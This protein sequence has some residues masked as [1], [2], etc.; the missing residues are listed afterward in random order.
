MSRAPV[1]SC[2]NDP[3]QAKCPKVRVV[4][5][6]NG[7]VWAPEGA[8]SA[9]RARAAFY[10]WQCQLRVSDGSPYKASGY[11]QM[12]ASSVCS[13]AVTA[14]ELYATL[15][16]H[17]NGA[18]YQMA[19][20]GARQPGGYGISLHVTYGCTSQGVNRYWRA[21]ADGWALLNGGWYHAYRERFNWLWCG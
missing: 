14:H 17:Y 11:A 3:T 7:T 9:R 2:P 19:M 4:A 5:E 18:W 1:G 12:N 6:D 13:Y 10:P 20:R 21:S 16:K 15:S 8:T